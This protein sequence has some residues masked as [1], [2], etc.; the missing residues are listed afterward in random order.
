MLDVARASIL[1]QDRQRDSLRA[2]S[3][4][5]LALATAVAGVLSV[6]E[7]ATGST[8]QTGT[9]FAG[10]VGQ[11]LVVIGAALAYAPQGWRS[12]PGY[13]GDSSSPAGLFEWPLEGRYLNAA[14]AVAITHQVDYQYNRRALRLING[15]VYLQ[16]LG[17]ALVTTGWTLN[18]FWL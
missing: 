12:N 16:L 7:L 11:L 18:A 9:F 4:W 1:E 5:N 15:F 6:G 17:L 3:T 2:R 8:M 14:Y 13:L 10:V